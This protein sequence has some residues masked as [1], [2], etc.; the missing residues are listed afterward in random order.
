MDIITQVSLGQQSDEGHD[1][2]GAK[3]GVVTIK[4]EGKGRKGKKGRDAAL[5]WVLSYSLGQRDVQGKRSKDKRNK[6]KEL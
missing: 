6:I 2:K 4:H 3:V 5:N 1:Q